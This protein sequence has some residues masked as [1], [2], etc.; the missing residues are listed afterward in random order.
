MLTIDDINKAFDN[1][2]SQTRILYDSI[3]TYTN[4]KYFLETAKAK[5]LASDQIEG[6][7]AE[8]REAKLRMALSEEYQAFHLAEMKLDN[9]KM[10]YKLA[11]LEIDRIA[12]IIQK[13]KEIE[14][15]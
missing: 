8:I 5:L 15:A 10:H 13:L 4:E 14:D 6:K 9:D 12:A 11:Q 1:L 7:N 2:K 3:E